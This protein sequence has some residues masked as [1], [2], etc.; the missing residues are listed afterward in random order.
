MTSKIGPQTVC[1]LSPM[2]LVLPRCG[3]TPLGMPGGIC[4][5][6]AG[7]LNLEYLKGTL[8]CPKVSFGGQSL[9]FIYYP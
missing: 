9:Y 5:Q 4:C 3:E 8:W 6:F 1:P 7:C 2:P